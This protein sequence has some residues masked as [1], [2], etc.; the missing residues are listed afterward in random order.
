M[1]VLSSLWT[2]SAS[3]SVKNLPADTLPIFRVAYL[4]ELR[5]EEQRWDRAV[6][7]SMSD[8]DLFEQ[9]FDIAWSVLERSDDLGET[10][11]ATQFLFTE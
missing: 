7:C 6:F 2:P 5:R 9:S 1:W 11:D 4:F 10:N 8:S 3:N